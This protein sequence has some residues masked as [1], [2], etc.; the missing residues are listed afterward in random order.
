[1][2]E[3]KETFFMLFLILQSCVLHERTDIQVVN[4]DTKQAI[5]VYEIERK[6]KSQRNIK[7]E[8]EY[9][10]LGIENETIPLGGN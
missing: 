9:K 7:R 6:P 1:M 2:L 3:M 4:P 8:E 5:K 10:R